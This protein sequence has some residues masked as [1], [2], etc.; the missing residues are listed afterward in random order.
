MSVTVLNPIDLVEMATDLLRTAPE[1]VI[2]L[3]VRRLCNIRGVE[4]RRILIRKL[5][6]DTLH[7]AVEDDRLLA[8][9]NL[10]SEIEDVATAPERPTQVALANVTTSEPEPREFVK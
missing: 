5:A 4:L 6:E 9:Q 8:G 7:V 3:A 10:M 2:L 1:A